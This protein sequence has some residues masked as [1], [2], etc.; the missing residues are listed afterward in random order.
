MT[1]TTPRRTVYLKRPVPENNN[2][3]Q[4]F[5]GKHGRQNRYRA[6]AAATVCAQS[7]N[8]SSRVSRNLPVLGAGNRHPSSRRRVPSCTKKRVRQELDHE[9]GRAREKRRMAW[10]EVGFL[11]RIGGSGESAGP[12]Q[13]TPASSTAWPTNAEVA[14]VAGKTILR[15]WIDLQTRL[16]YW[17]TK[18]DVQHAPKRSRSDAGPSKSSATFS[19]AEWP[20]CATSV[21]KATSPFA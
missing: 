12:R 6:R 3:F 21:R 2:F 7:R 1:G 9:P 14:D 16:T 13:S 18:G 4:V 17:L 10:R 19:R 8:A 11:G 15:D 5:P 20:A